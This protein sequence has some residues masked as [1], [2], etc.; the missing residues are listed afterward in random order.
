MLLFIP[1][2]LKPGQ[3]VDGWRV[4]KAL[5][6]GSFGAVYLVEKEGQRFALKM[7]MH[8]ASSGD[9]EQSDARLMREMVCLAQVSGHPNIVRM[10]AHGRWND[11]TRGWLYVVED[12][13][14]GYTLGEWM[15][16]THPTAHEV[17]ALFV[18]LASA[19]AHVHAR[20]VFHRDLK[21]SNILVRASDGEPFLLDFGVGSYARA[22]EL[23][24]SPLPPG[25]RR[26]RSPEATK[27]LREHGE[28]SEARYTFKATDDVYALGICLY[29]LL[30][31]ARPWSESPAMF[32][33]GRLEL[34][35]P[36]SLN[37]RVPA[38]LGAAVLHFVARDP[39]KRAPTA[40]VMRRELTALL[41]EVG[42]AWR[43]PFHVPK[44]HVQLAPEAPPL[45]P[46]QEVPAP[47]AR[48]GLVT[49]RGAFMVALAVLLGGLVLWRFTTPSESLPTAQRT[50]L[51]PSSAWQVNPEPK[52][53]APPPAPAT[54]PPEVASPV[55]APE[56]KE[57]PPVKR[58]PS[59]MSPPPAPAIRKPKPLAV[60][61]GW[62]PAEWGGF[63]KK[64]AGL[65]AA[66]AL[67]MGCPGAQVRPEAAD[68]P[69]AA[70]KAMF[71]KK[72]D[73][74][75]GLRKNAYVAFYADARQ[76]RAGHDGIFREGPVTGE[77]YTDEQRALPK[78][79][80]LY[81]Y[82]WTGNKDLLLGRYTEARLPNGQRVPVCIEMGN[83]DELGWTTR[84][85]ESKPGEIVTRSNLSGIAVERWR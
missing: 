55:S 29:D 21:L 76:R 9:A 61:P 48:Q 79:T 78:G 70:R 73:G 80:L 54:M 36:H 17:V 37:P 11:A 24:D 52:Q 23:T 72:A 15:E 8:R 56:Q 67:Q 71:T 26:Y 35:A 53:P 59:P 33:G 45:M 38:A 1:A 74:G 34:P 63:L 51:A 16:K 57:S 41:P 7:A 20:G 43:E 39:E 3:M 4:V 83:E 27:F 58:A 10:Y 12:Y 82:L 77:V 85:E 75:L 62:P 84:A 81:G 5:G 18:K 30:T 13:V 14:E 69:E 60:S 6:S 44:P 19:L 40:E 22:P 42:I 64:C 46:S 28:E 50:P 32:L 68:C 66:A 65:T 31:I 49:A 25:T 47:A 2:S